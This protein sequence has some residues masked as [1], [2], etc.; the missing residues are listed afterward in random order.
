MSSM[1]CFEASA[2][3]IAF[4][5]LFFIYAAVFFGFAL[6]A[7]GAGHGTAI[8]F[9]PLIAS[10]LLIPAGVMAAVGGDWFRPRN[11]VVVMSAHY[12]VTAMYVVSGFVDGVPESLVKMWALSKGV[13]IKAIA[14][15]VAGQAL[16]WVAYGLR[17]RYS[18]SYRVGSTI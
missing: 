14:L 16:M 15:Y 8:L 3:I 11:F 13:F 17:V 12:V 10:V 9:V 6:D 4:L 7:A 1:R 5:V 2:R 18:H